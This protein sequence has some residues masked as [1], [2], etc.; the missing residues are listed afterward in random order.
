MLTGLSELGC[1]TVFAGST[2][3]SET[4]WTAE[5]IENLKKAWVKDVCIYYAS[6]ADF[7]GA[8]RIRKFHDFF[9]KTPPV[10]SRLYTPG[11]LKKFFSE[12]VS[13]V[14]P[15]LILMNYAHWDGLLEHG[16]LGSVRRAIEI[17]DLIT[18][19]VRMWTALGKSLPPVPLE[20]EKISDNL[21]QEDFFEKLELR[22]DPAEFRVYDKY[23]FTITLSSGEEEQI[24]RNTH[25]TKTVL[26]PMTFDPVVIPNSYSGNAVFPTGPHPYNV[27]GY[28][29]FLKR[30]LPAVLKKAGDFRLEMTGY[31]CNHVKE[32][33]DVIL[34]GFVQD[35]KDLYR[36]ARFL[37]CPVFGGT[38]QQVKI[39]EAMAHGVPVVALA[40]S[41]QASPI[42]HGI[43]GFIANNAEEFAEYAIH[44][45]ND[46]ELCRRMGDAARD[47][48]GAGFSRELL[49]QKLSLILE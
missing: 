43:N 7:R 39:V 8:A 38:G 31:W 29:Y 19:N 9:G 20:S 49:L 2:L 4:Q 10:N 5:S 46:K 42:R 18:L 40:F 35:M 45:W 48:V 12:L 44:L 23:D 37:I 21:L 33:K 47:S 14:K 25:K 27:Q 26:I 1:E 24:K 41:A 3:F 34:G 17:H 28:F 6:V 16:K 30:V 11:R 36:D 22:A 13:R 15:D 32:E